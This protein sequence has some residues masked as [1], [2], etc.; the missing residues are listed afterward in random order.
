LQLSVATE[1]GGDVSTITLSEPTLGEEEHLVTYTEQEVMHQL[2]IESW[3][4]LSKDKMMRFAAMMP[5]MDTEVALKVIEQFPAFKEFALDTVKEIEKAHEGT[6]KANDKSQV[7]FYA[8]LTDIREILKGELSNDELTWEQRKW[9]IEQI[10][11]QGKLAFQKD[12]ENKKF[13]DTILG[14]VALVGV[15]VVALGLVFVGGKMM[16]EHGDGLGEVE[17]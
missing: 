10:Q 3:R 1:R 14:K 6:V 11:D 2:G 13:L 7:H 17:A 5:E 12:S 15:G 9:I 8:T 16:V 4:N